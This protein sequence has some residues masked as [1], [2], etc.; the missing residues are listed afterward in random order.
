M[1]LQILQ[2]QLGP[3]QARSIRRE[4]RKVMLGQTKVAFLSKKNN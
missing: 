1:I 4:H 2:L 3:K